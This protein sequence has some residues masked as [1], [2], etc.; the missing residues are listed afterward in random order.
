MERE[1]ERTRMENARARIRSLRE[2]HEIRKGA[3]QFARSRVSRARFRGCA[4]RRVSFTV[5]SLSPRIYGRAALL[6]NYRG[7]LKKPRST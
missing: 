2:T 6:L 5:G 7:L 3:F 4:Y 1:A